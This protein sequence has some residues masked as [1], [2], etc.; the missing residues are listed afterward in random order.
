MNHHNIQLLFKSGLG[1]DIF[2]ATMSQKRMR[3]VLAHITF[4]DK[5]A[6]KD[7][8]SSDGSPAGRDMF[9][10]FNK[11]CSKYVIPSEYLAIDEM[12]YPMRH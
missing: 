7:R 10:M 3:F 12:L 8:W 5:K 2:G 1:P 6:R 11:N 9:D 4:N